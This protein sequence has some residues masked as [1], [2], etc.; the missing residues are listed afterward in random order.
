MMHSKI[1]QYKA[2]R[3]NKSV[4]QNWMQYL[5]GIVL[6]LYVSNTFAQPSSL[7]LWYRQ[8]AQKWTDALPIGNGNLGAM[9][10]GGVNEDRVQFNESSLWTGQPRNYNRPNANAYLQAIRDLLAEGKQAQAEI[11]AEKQFMGLK[12]MPDSI[13]QQQKQDW[14]KEQVEQSD[15]ASPLFKNAIWKPMQLPTLN[16]WEHLGLEGLDG[17]LWFKVSFEVPN[18]L[19]GKD[20]T[21][22]L[23]RIRDMDRSFIN[24]HLIGS[25]EG[26]TLKR[27]Y[28]IPAKYIQTGTNT[29]YVQ[30]FNFYDKGGFT[31]IKE[32]R[33]NFVLYSKELGVDK[34]LMLPLDWQYF[35]QNN[36]PPAFP[37]YQA[38]YLPFGDLYFT[39]PQY[40]QVLNYQRALDLTNAVAHVKYIADGVEYTREYIASNPHQAI[41]IHLTAN[42]L[43]KINVQAH[44]DAVHILKDTVSH[45][46]GTLALHV[47]VQHGA[48]KGTALLYVKNTGGQLVFKNGQVIIT[49]ANEASFYLVAATNFKND[50]DVSGKDQFIA[51]NKLAAVKNTNFTTFKNTHVQDYQKLFNRFSISFGNA[52]FFNIPTDERILQFDTKEDNGMLALYIQYARYLLIASSREN[53]NQPS[54]LQGI[55]NDLL[56]PPWGS[57][58]TTNINLEMNYWSADLLNLPNNT[59]PLFNKLKDLQINGA[60]TAKAY[61]NT[62]GWVLH[63]NT[64]I[65]NGTAPI[66]AS[67]HGIWETGAAWMS[68]HIWDHYLYTQDIQ[69][70]KTY[71][72]ILKG[73]AQFFN[74]N[75]YKDIHTGWLISSPSNSPENGGL[76]AGPTMDHQII[77]GLFKSTIAA[78]ILLHQDSL[79][80]DSLQNQ[81]T[82]IAPNQIGKY[83]QLQE[84]L[85]DMDDTTNK[86]RHV[87]HLWAVY[88][89]NEITWQDSTMMKAARQSLLYRGDDGTGWSLAWKTN[90]WARFKDGEHAFMM[91]KKLLSP[92]DMAN[93]EAEK[94]GVYKNM[95]DAHPPFQIDGN[96]GGAAGM[97]EMLVQSHE[98][99]IQILP[100]LPNALATG[101]IHGVCVRG[102]FEINMTWKDHAITQLEVISKAGTTCWL[103]YGSTQ[104][105]FTTQK[106]KHYH[107][108]QKLQ[109]L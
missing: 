29:L 21:L 58:Y 35:I 83:G 52:H 82:L 94:G 53:S 25:T 6:L 28:T 50:H 16:G 101:S 87:S 40:K 47:K 18:N 13:Y 7:S 93:G 108:N 17:A 69:F 5:I 54:N 98:K 49:N 99:Y 15:F 44:F 41:G 92:A 65:W 84:W 42:K 73:A 105:H 106:G 55:W 63:H 36:T 33:K 79:L 2:V 19:W 70:L 34:G 66:N 38:N 102:G 88:P 62:G 89:G 104:V 86:H 3:Q 61:Y 10:F 64:D 4:S 24:G 23:G 91:A 22:D 100:A 20:L 71:Y 9:L 48:I 90:L 109:I 67:N 14:I 85:Q 46:N 26:N 31:G 68:Q 1:Y 32:P 51:T 75:L 56:T 39:Y 37:Q 78:S 96:F 72:P 77:R 43:G 76:V 60:Q 11:L 81:Y 57:K 103:Q 97:M 8:P 45:S 80:R 27:S 95:M 12:D 74:Q 107:L 59:K 30:V